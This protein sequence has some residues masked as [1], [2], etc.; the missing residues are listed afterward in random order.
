VG[1]IVAAHIHNFFR[2]QHNLD[3]IKK[4]RKAGV[5][6][7]DIEVAEKG[8][9]PLEGQ[10]WVLTGALSSLTRDEAK[11]RL[12]SL[13][14]KVAGSV[15]KKTTVVVAGE[16][17]GSKLDKAQELGIEVMDEDGLIALFNE[18]GV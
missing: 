7:P 2:E 14:A 15:S 9:Q 3:V 1:P 5:S 13:G 16:A 10:T 11:A 8:E 12:Q 6:W 18:H 4:L 17:A